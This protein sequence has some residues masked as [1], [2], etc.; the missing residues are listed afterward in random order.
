[1]LGTSW[2]RSVDQFSATVV[3]KAVPMSM[4]LRDFMLNWSGRRLKR[5]SAE[6]ARRLEMTEICI[7]LC[8]TAASLLF[9]RR[10]LSDYSTR[11]LLAHSTESHWQWRDD[12]AGYA[13]RR[14]IGSAKRA[15]AP[16]VYVMH[17]R[18][19]SEKGLGN[20][21]H[22]KC[23]RRHPRGYVGAKR[24]GYRQDSNPLL[25]RMSAAITWGLLYSGPR[26]RA[27]TRI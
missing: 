7:A 6:V 2:P 18:C 4:R 16:G 3:F 19:R 26:K 10:R 8:A 14:I 15:R 20:M 22:A 25:A 23:E 27:K 21:A 11:Q 1:M 9:E 17:G 24:G 13:S 12:V 5:I